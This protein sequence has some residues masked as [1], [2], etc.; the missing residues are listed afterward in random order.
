[1]LRYRNC[2]ISFPNL[3]LH[4]PNLSDKIITQ[5]LIFLTQDNEDSKVAVT[6]KIYP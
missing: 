1:M 2:T 3:K 5:V 4:H 6:Q